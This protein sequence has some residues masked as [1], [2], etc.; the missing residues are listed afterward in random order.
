MRNKTAIS[1]P[2]AVPNSRGTVKP[3]IV[4]DFETDPFLHGHIP[5]VFLAGIFDGKQVIQ[6]WGD[7]AIE[8]FS[9]YLESLKAHY[10]FFHNG[11]KFDF[12]FLRPWPLKAPLR[13][14]N[15]R[16][17]SA[18]FGKHTLRDSFS[19]L[20]FAL[21]Q[22]QKTEI[23][24]DKFTKENREHH[25][26]E[27]LAY[28]AD[29]LRNLHDLVS[30]FIERFGLK[31]TAPSAAIQELNK[32]HP[33]TRKGPSHDE[34]FR[35][36]YYGGR[37]ECFESGHLPGA[38]SCH[39]VNSMYPYVMAN[40]D[41]P[42]GTGFAFTTARR[43]VL[44]GERPGFAF[45]DCTSR[46]ALPLR[47]DDGKLEFPHGRHT[48]SCTLHELRKA[49]QLGL[50]RIHRIESAWVASE[51]SRFGDFV[52]V[53]SGE[54]I[55][56]KRDGNRI[57][58][59]FAK[60]ILNSAYGKFGANPERYYDYDFLLEDD[61]FP[62]GWDV[63]EDLGWMCVIRKPSALREFSYYDVATAA[64]ITGA[65]RSVLLEAIANS[66]R[67][68][69]C[70]TD[71]IISEG[72]RDAKTG[73]EL[74]AWKLEATGDTAI[75]LAK[76]LYAL[77]KNGEIVKQASKGVRMQS[78]DYLAICKGEEYI[79]LRDAPTFRRDGSSEFLER[80]ISLERMS[81]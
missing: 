16:I 28:H 17:V 5:Q 35:P 54:K 27:I 44:Q 19:I 37:V 55:Q 67:P 70:D 71:S 59:L 31:L 53:F 74:G 61:V 81:K 13:I 45:V 21:E 72:L 23:D 29:D 77:F 57:G 1:F 33:V 56:A 3:W 12:F 41:H 80:R 18:R 32:L 24:Y 36:F 46:G 40:F 62:M 58:E 76:K 68:I 48:F 43:P 50:V 66:E 39:D 75:I 11:G 6:F 65:A 69:Y 42:T 78:D 49:Y 9:S 51:F 52:S 2:R 64:S 10:I 26:A 20:P 38:W 4:A 63:H 15:G 34:K 30:A 79:Y 60:L 7:D 47:Q 73:D 25:R 8:K 22:Y 14:I